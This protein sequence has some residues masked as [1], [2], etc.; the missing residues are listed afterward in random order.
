MML[1]L[2]LDPPEV[3]KKT[4]GEVS[5]AESKVIRELEVKI[6]KHK[7][8]VPIYNTFKVK[9]EE[10][11]LKEFNQENVLLNKTK[12]GVCVLQLL[13]WDLTS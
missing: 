7:R 1:S 2:G 12:S 9:A 10:K 8:L 5:E 3:S 6:M 11:A 4:Q 13:G